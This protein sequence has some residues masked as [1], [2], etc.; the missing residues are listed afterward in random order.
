MVAI[1]NDNDN[2][3]FTWHLIGEQL[4]AFTTHKHTFTQ[5]I[6]M[7]SD[8]LMWMWQSLHNIYVYTSNH[9]AVHLEC[10]QL[11]FVN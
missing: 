3:L 2:V 6:T 5:I 8:M 1:A 9:L 4:S 11:L 7:S 10:I